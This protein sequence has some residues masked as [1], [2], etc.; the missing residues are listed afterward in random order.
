MLT[1]NTQKQGTLLEAVTPTIDR[2]VAAF[3]V[4]RR[5]EGKR[6]STLTF[7]RKR[8]GTFVDYCQSHNVTDIGAIDAMLLRE[9]LLSLAERH[10][11]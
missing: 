4:A 10:N 3:L 5:A 6:E 8:L 1:T 2:W 9:F 7:Y 11:P